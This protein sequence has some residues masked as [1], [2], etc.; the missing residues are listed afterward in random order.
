MQNGTSDGNDLC[1][2]SVV[3]KLQ[4]QMIDSKTVPDNIRFEFLRAV[5][6]S[7]A[8]IDIECCVLWKYVSGM[9]CCYC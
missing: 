8:V 6:I 7:S 4:S 2:L 9:R 3:C 5:E 1:L